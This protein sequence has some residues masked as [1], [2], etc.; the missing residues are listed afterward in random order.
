MS[1]SSSDVELLGRGRYLVGPEL[2]SGGMATVH[3]ALLTGDLG[4]SRIVAIKRIHPTLAVDQGLVEA[5]RDEARIAARIRH[6]NVVAVVDVLADAEDVQLVLEYIHGESAASLMRVARARG[7]L[8][9]V[10]VAVAIAVD[11]LHGL[12]AAHR[13]TDERGTSLGVVHRDVSPQNIMVG[14][15]GI[16]RVLDFGIA[17]AQ[18]RAAVTRDGMLKGKLAYMAP[19]QL[20]GDATAQSDCYALALVLWEMLV[21]RSPFSAA[22]TQGETLASV[23][24]GV[25]EAPSAE[26][27][28]IPAAL[29]AVIM[30]ALSA[31]AR[32]R[33]DSAHAM[34]D[35]L[36][37]TGLVASRSAVSATVASLASEVLEERAARMVQLER[38][39]ASGAAPSVDEQR[40]DAMT[41]LTTSTTAPLPVSRRS[42]LRSSLLAAAALA[43][44]VASLGM[45]RAR[46]PG[47][48]SAHDVAAT[49]PPVVSTASAVVGAPAAS[50]SSS[51]PAAPA[52][53]PSADRVGPPKTVDPRTSRRA[54]AAAK[55]TA[56]APTDCSVPYTVDANG[57]RLYRRE[58]FQR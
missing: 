51:T 42:R 58:C 27:G 21:G 10:D 53:A 25:R 18:N 34:A 12:H 40:L 52:Q 41:P 22:S 4:F 17:K 15:D 13:A 19:E 29:D 38:S 50:A 26:R 20:G 3:M 32:E 55:S 2:G 9:P 5:I 23:L 28:E 49:P 30:C 7:Q 43:V 37:R 24:R 56:I 48:S 46:A 39:P 14:A 47:A 54:P 36:E 57:F 11:A 6:P 44:L 8:L 33:F 1:T 16:A 35:A 45:L 31:A